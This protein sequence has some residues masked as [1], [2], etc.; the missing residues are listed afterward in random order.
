M[1]KICFITGSRAE[2]GILAHLMHLVKDSPEADLQIVATNMHLSPRHGMTVANIV[3]DGFNVDFR[4]PSYPEGDEPSDTVTAMTKTMNGLSEAFKVLRPDIIVILGDRY[5][6]LAAASAALIFNIPIAH[7][8]G[9]E[10]T[11][12]AYDDAIRHAVTKMSYLHFASTRTYADRIISMG[13][14]PARVFDVGALG[15]ENALRE[16]LISRSELEDFLNFNLGEKFCLVTF[17]PVTLQPGEEELQTR[18]LTGAL[19]QFIPL[20]WKLL[21]TM[22]NSDTGGDKVA[23]ILENW[24]KENPDSVINVKSLGRKRYF[25][26]LSHSSALIGN[27]SSGIIEAP[28]FRIPTINVGDRQKGRIMGPSVIS[29]P[30]EPEKIISSLKKAMEPDFIRNIRQLPMEILN[31]YY[32]K[33]TAQDILMHLL[34]EPLSVSKSFHDI[35]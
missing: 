2:Y 4:I 17:H 21:V 20:G 33:N 30:C 13:E 26:A 14:D 16:S 1:R 31:P 32:K 7:I 8:H 9:G 12:G 5:E 27:S 28:A 22:P 19:S 6:M 15:V 24:R 25:S 3:E 18:N 29:C 11:E 23:Q 34:K 10:V 35:K